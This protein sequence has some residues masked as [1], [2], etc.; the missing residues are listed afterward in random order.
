MRVVSTAAIVL[1]LASVTLRGEDSLRT[2]VDRGVAYVADYRQK[3]A[4]LVA[5]E[6]YEQEVRYPAPALSRGRDLTS[7][8]V[9]L[10]DFLLVRG[11]GGAWL[12]FRDVFER[13]GTPVR[14]RQ[15]R[16][17]ALFLDN[18]G[19]AF[20]QAARIAKESARYNIGN[21][22][23]NINVP[24]M[25]LE[26]LT[27]AHRSGFDFEFEGGAGSAVRIV[28]YTE[29]NRPTYIRTTNDRDLP[30]SGRYWIHEAT[31]RIER[32]ELRASDGGG[33]DAQITVTYRPDDIAG[34]WV[35][36]RMEEHYSQKNDQSEIR[37]TAVYSR[38]RRF[39]ITTSDEL[40]K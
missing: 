29:R 15:E 25:A 1:A 35:P 12:P 39:Q 7:S 38:Y 2:V 11:P 6:R 16:L 8:T 14:D 22:N 27:A 5:Q 34:L 30:A 19:A 3:L 37:G 9:L 10:S 24:T 26:F 33:L 36:D 4:M 28:R 21:V 13:D 40:A 17:S 31:G 32:S 23:R 18:G 20:D